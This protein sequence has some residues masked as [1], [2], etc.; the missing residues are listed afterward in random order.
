MKSARETVTRGA[1]ATGEAGHSPGQGRTP[2]PQ[3]RLSQSRTVWGGHRGGLASHYTHH[4]KTHLRLQEP[5]CNFLFAKRA[6][7]S[8]ARVEAGRTRITTWIFL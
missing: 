5:V 1:R 8:G 2:L 6:E 3:P 4:W 7:P